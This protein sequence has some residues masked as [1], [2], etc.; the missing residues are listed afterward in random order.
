MSGEN[1]YLVQWR[2]VGFVK[3]R[4]NWDYGGCE[5]NSFKEKWISTGN[6]FEEE[7]FYL[8]EL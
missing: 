4:F 1:R 8:D 6:H 3:I 2:L 5:T 7:D